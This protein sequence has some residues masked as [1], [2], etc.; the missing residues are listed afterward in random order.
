MDPLE[1]RAR[2]VAD[3][4]AR[5]A[6]LHEAAGVLRAWSGGDHRGARALIDEYDATGGSDGEVARLA[7]IVDAEA[8]PG[9]DPDWGG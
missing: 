5:R 4:V 3:G 2:K 6:A 7:A 8:R 1:D 9:E